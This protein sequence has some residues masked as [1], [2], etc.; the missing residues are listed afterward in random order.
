M[1]D[2]AAGPALVAQ[3]AAGDVEAFERLYDRYAPLAFGLIRRILAD[4]AAAEDVLQE[5]FWQVWREAA[6]YD[7]GRGSVEAWL[8]MRARTR[9]I[10]R[11]RAQRRAGRQTLPLDEQGAAAPAAGP[12]AAVAAESRGLVESLLARL[13]EPQRRVLELAFFGGLTQTE[14]A[15]RMGDP[16]GTVKTRS[17][18]GLERLRAMLAAGERA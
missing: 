9:A 17:R 2:A 14:I 6:A 5:V 15:A 3:I 16:L 18:L 13:P 4:R 7:P 10:D 11:F 12:D 1:N 8:L